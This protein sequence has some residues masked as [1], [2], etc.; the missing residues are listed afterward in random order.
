MDL[1]RGVGRSSMDS[2]KRIGRML[3]FLIN[4]V[5]LLIVLLGFIF[6]FILDIGIVFFIFICCF[7]CF[8]FWVDLVIC[9]CRGFFVDILF[10][11]L[12]CFVVVLCKLYFEY[13]VY[14]FL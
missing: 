6:V 11:F 2:F 4:M 14:I 3:F 5:G 9:G 8:I 1:G 7:F 10:L 13:R 12:G